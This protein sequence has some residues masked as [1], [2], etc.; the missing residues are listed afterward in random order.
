MQDKVIQGKGRR[1][2]EVRRND[3]IKTFLDKGDQSLSPQRQLMVRNPTS[4]AG[5]NQTRTSVDNGSNGGQTSGMLSVY[6]QGRSPSP[7]NVGQPL[8][9]NAHQCLSS[10]LSGGSDIARAGSGSAVLGMPREESPFHD[11]HRA[12]DEDDPFLDPNRPPH[13]VFV[14][15]DGG[16]IRDFGMGES[17]HGYGAVSSR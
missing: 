2:S 9:Y 13:G 5:E 6:T 1:M 10:T 4:F 11:T 12:D 15:E 14:H 3:T 8:R 7:F 17:S 16:S